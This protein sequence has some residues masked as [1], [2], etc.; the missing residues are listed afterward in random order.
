MRTVILIALLCLLG[1][2]LAGSGPI[3][4]NAK[5]GKA[6]EAS[7]LAR[8]LKKY[9]LIFFGEWHGNAAIHSAQ[10]SLL[11]ELQAVDPRLALSF[12]MFERDVQTWLDQYLLGEITE[13]EFLAYSR[14]WPNYATDYRPLVEFAREQ[15]LPAIAANVP[16]PLAG[17]AARLGEKFLEELADDEKAWV[18]ERISAPEGKYKERFLATMR[19]NM[20]HGDP[21]DAQLYD[22]LFLA[23]CVKD[24]TMAESI[25]QAR[26]RFPKHRI[27]HFNGDF[28]SRES[29]GTVE[30][31]LER[32]PKLKAAVISPL[33]EGETIPEGAERIADWFILAPRE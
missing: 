3:F 8:Q 19:Q 27:I 1:T 33:A 15:G 17:R 9:D 23:Q 22:N 21:G 2:A 14:P 4:V 16:R 11:R 6:L 7:Q 32:S 25:L 13:E 20:G 5:T 26:Q 29:L 28:H 24:D 18:A 10:A 30:R 31:V 12:E